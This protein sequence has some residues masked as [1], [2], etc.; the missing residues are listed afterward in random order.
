MNRQPVVLAVI[1]EA[2]LPELIHEMTD[3]RPGCADHLG[4]VILT[5]FRKHEFGSAF[6]AEMSEQQEDARE[7]LFARIK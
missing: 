1:D 6:L 3:T 5:D 2:Q 7:T 4:Q